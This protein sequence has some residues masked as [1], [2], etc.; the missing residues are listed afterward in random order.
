MAVAPTALD[1]LDVQA[2]QGS[3][4]SDDSTPKEDGGEDAMQRADSR[5]DVWSGWSSRSG[6]SR[7]GSGRATGASV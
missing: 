2:Q 5:L 6:P 3:S 1:A 7:S 4:G